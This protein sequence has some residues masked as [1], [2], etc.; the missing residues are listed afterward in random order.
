MTTAAK[1]SGITKTLNHG[2]V[3]S[4][5]SGNSSKD[6]QF[7]AAAGASGRTVTIASAA[8][9]MASPRYPKS[10]MILAEKME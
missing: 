1:R 3:D 2:R 10:A 5:R 8:W 9:A 4:M 6:R 7:S